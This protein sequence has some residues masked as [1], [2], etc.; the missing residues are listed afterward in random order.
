VNF[1]I[2]KLVDRYKENKVLG[3][4][5]TMVA[6]CCMDVMAI[7]LAQILLWLDRHR[8]RKLCSTNKD[9]EAKDP[10][11]LQSSL[12]AGEYSPVKPIDS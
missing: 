9:E 7:A 2:G 6:L 4:E 11:T 10:T 12:N 8:D 5:W 1:G 3:Y